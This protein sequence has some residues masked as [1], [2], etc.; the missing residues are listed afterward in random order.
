MGQVSSAGKSSSSGSAVAAL[1]SSALP[2]LGAIWP[3]F[4]AECRVSNALGAIGA[5]A[6]RWL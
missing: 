1:P 3:A 4:V 2:R 5:G 6:G